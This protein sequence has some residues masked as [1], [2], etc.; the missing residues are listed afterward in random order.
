M[1][2]GFAYYYQQSQMRRFVKLLAEWLISV[3]HFSLELI[4]PNERTH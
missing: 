3:S 1:I 2:A 4:T